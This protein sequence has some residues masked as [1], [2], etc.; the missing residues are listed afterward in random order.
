MKQNVQVKVNDEE[1]KYTH[2]RQLH[3]VIAQVHEIVPQNSK[4]EGHISGEN[5]NYEGRIFIKTRIGDFVAKAKARNL[6]AL[7]AKLKAKILRQIVNWRE[8]KASKKRYQRRKNVLTLV[9]D[10]KQT[11]TQ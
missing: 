10:E 11:N 2:K 1:F 3:S 5:G 9:H 4:L 8:K 7:I 6:F